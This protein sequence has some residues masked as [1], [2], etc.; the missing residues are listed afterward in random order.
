MAMPIEDAFTDVAHAELMPPQWVIQDL[1][2]V[3]LTVLAGPPKKSY[4]STI[5]IVEACMAA[6]WASTALPVWAECILGGPTMMFSYEA[7][8]GEVRWV[9][10]KGLRI[11]PQEH[12]IYICDDPWA[13][14]LHDHQSRTRLIQFL[15]DKKPLLVVMDPFRNM[16]QGDENDSSVIVECLSDVRRW[17]HANGAAGILVHH[18]SKPSKEGGEVGGMYSMRGSSALPGLV[19][20]MLVVEPTRQEGQITMNATFKRGESWKRTMVLGVPGYGWPSQGYEVLPE[21]ATAAQSIWRETEGRRS[22]ATMDT[23]VQAC[24]NVATVRLMLSALVRNRRIVLT[25]VERAMFLGLEE[26]D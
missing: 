9:I 24:G 2:P 1:V 3:G 18:V 5:T 22:I 17:L 12:R 20:G 6:R 11:E 10:E 8:A 14:Q 16:F 15:D 25:P 4:K 7:K 23:L 19:D 21:Q 13:F 26:E